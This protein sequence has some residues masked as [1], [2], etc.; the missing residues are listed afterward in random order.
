MQRLRAE[1]QRQELL[2][3]SDEPK[4]AGA[5]ISPTMRNYGYRAAMALIALSLMA[6]LGCNGFG[7]GNATEPGSTPN[8]AAQTAFRM[9]GTIG[10]PFV[11]TISDQRSSWNIQGVVPLN[12]IIANGNNPVRMVATK[13]TNN[14][15]ILSIQVIVGFAVA[16]VSS[17][18]SNY[19]MVVGSVNGT[20]KSFAAPAAPDARFYV[21][22]P[23][24]GV[25]NATVEDE[26]V[27]YVLQSRAP[28][29]ILFDSPNNNSSS[30]QVDGIFNDV[31]GGPLSI[32]LSFN[33]HVVSAGGSGTVTVKIN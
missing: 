31:S 20:L 7:S 10:T 33:G 23:A 19:G 8:V 2:P 24:N 26:T 29:V 28:C 11:G 9:V 1:Q 18:F 5:L 13:L 27:A 6:T 12:V 3:L 14:N 32:N 21:N 4:F 22:G 16:T 25:F 15:A 17:T 30:G